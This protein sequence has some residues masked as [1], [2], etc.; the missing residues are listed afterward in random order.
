[1]VL[2]VSYLVIELVPPA[3]GGQETE[4]T[5]KLTFARSVRP[6]PAPPRRPCLRPLRLYQIFNAASGLL[7]CSIAFNALTEQ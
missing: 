2:L 5:S 6:P 3:A 4:G 1:M 7:A